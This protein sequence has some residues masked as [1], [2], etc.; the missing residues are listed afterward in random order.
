MYNED[1]AVDFH[2]DE[3][4]FHE[5]ADRIEY[6]L[7]QGTSFEGLSIRGIYYDKQNKIVGYDPFPLSP[8]AGSKQ[9][10]VVTLVDMFKSIDEM[11]DA[12]KKPVLDEAK[13]EAK[14]K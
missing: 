5:K 9:E 11:L 13:L 3:P 8:L 10:V 1:M 14:F 6:R 2:N 4:C 12:T 7:V